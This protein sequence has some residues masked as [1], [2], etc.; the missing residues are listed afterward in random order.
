MDT[1]QTGLRASWH[2]DGITRREGLLSGLVTE[3]TPTADVSP[4]RGS[5]Y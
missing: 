1:E 5:F 2:P 4:G 3:A